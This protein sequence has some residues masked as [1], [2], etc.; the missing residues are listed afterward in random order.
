MLSPIHVYVLRLRES[1]TF[2]SSPKAT[3][4]H[5]KREKSNKAIERVL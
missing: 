4:Q 5:I 1:L 3:I 2:S